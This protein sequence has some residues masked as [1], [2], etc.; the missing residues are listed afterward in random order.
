MTGRRMTALFVFFVCIASTVQA[1][2]RPDVEFKIFQFPANMIPRVD[3]NTDDWN[4]VPDTYAVGTD[5]LRDTVYNNK[6]DRSDLDVKVKV[7]WV[8][9]MNR[10]YF[11]YEAYD[12]FWDFEQ[13]DLHNDIFEIVVDA[14]LS[15]GPLIPQLREDKMYDEKE[16]LLTPVDGRFQ[17]HGV[18]AQNYHVYTPAVGKPWTMV[19]GCNHWIYEL[20]WANA[21]SSYNFKQ[22]ES[23]KYILEFWVT[24]FDYAPY[25]GP[26]RAVESKLTEDT[27]IGMSWC[28][29]EYDGEHES[30]RYKAFWNLSH[31]TEMYGDA[32]K[33]VAFR[34]MPLEDRFRDP[35]EAQWDFTVID[36]DRRLVS[37]K[38]LSYGEIT[39]WHWD[40][41]DGATSTEQNPIH[42]YKEAGVYYVVVLHV[43]GPD[44]KARM[45]KVWDVMIR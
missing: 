26:E 10:L 5:Q 15:G 36:M 24:P 39:S 35:I 34:L 25:E 23:G 29:L 13:P 33:A 18:H 6:M 40:F 45:S 30:G 2:E 12:N 43:E 42:E 16:G 4:V 28:V 37:F 32:S 9:G 14:D 41:G 27:I 17:F 21:A 38:D 22:G 44:G 11:L 7:G 8:K 31:V 3:G 1:L 20:P 19:W